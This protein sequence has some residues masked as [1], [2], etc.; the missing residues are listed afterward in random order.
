M[1]SFPIECVDCGAPGAIEIGR[2]PELDLSQERSFRLGFPALPAT[3]DC[4]KCRAIHSLEWVRLDGQIYPS[5]FLVSTIERP[6]RQIEHTS[7]VAAKWW[8]DRLEQG[9]REKFEAT[10]AALVA[11]DLESQGHCE[12]VCDHDPFGHLLTALRAAGVECH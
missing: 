8:G 7:Q 2:L 12:L 10:L 5:Q 9:D 1:M 4:P 11:A 3:W 6:N